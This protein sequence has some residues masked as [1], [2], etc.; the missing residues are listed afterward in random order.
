MQLQ[1]AP[2][3]ERRPTSGRPSIAAGIHGR[4]DPAV[5]ARHRDSPCARAEPRDASGATGHGRRGRG[6]ADPGGARGE[7]R[8]RTRSRSPAPRRSAL[9][10][11]ASCGA[12]RS[13]AMFLAS[14]VT[15]AYLAFRFEWRFGVAAVLSTAHDVLVTL[16]FIK[17]TAHRGLADASSPPSSRCSATRATTRSSSSIACART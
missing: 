9:R 16:S 12:A 7:V 5:R 8:R 11:A 17:L 10:W 14:L 6:R 1:F 13:I 2:A 15:L 4:R 3:A